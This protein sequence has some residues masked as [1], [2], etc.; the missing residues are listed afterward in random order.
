MANFRSKQTIPFWPTAGPAGA[1]ADRRRGHF[2]A[3]IK[4]LRRERYFKL[5]RALGLAVRVG[6]SRLGSAATQPHQTT[7]AQPGLLDEREGFFLE[8][9]HLLLIARPCQQHAVEAG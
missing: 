5:S 9:A 3:R 4:G 1:P 8:L 6:Q 7:L 2:I